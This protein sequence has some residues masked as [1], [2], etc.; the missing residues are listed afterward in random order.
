MQ[1]E[2]AFIGCGPSCPPG[3]VGTG[4]S[5]P[6][7]PSWSQTVAAQLSTRHILIIIIFARTPIHVSRYG[8]FQNIEFSKCTALLFILV[9]LFNIYIG[10]F[11]ISTPS[12]QYL[13]PKHEIDI[14]FIYIMFFQST[15]D[16]GF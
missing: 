14:L 8:R 11:L 1:A 3:R 5:W 12:Y 2:L 4:P 16:D 15:F 13:I 6:T 7:G 10:D 9:I